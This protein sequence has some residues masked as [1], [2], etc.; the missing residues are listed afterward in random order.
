MSPILSGEQ[1]VYTAMDPPALIHRFYI[2]VHT[3]K[4]IVM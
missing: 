3:L 4:D 1:Q 2:S